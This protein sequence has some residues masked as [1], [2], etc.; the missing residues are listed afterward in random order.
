MRKLNTIY[1]L[2]NKAYKFS[3]TSKHTMFDQIYENIYIQILN[4]YNFMVIR[5]ILIWYCKHL[6]FCL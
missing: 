2:M 5:F 4:K 1:I 3:Q 6:D